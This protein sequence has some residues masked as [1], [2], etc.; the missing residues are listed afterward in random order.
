V[1]VTA[2]LLVFITLMI[3]YV[4]DFSV[5]GLFEEICNETDFVDSPVIHLVN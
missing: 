4:F 1:I 3:L 5:N 2:M